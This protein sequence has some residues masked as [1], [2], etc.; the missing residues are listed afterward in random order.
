MKTISFIFLALL[1]SFVYG[2][3]NP[4]Q[5]KNKA[6]S[7][8]NEA[9]WIWHPNEA[10]VGEVVSFRKEFNMKDIPV[11]ADFTIT[12]DNSYIL[13]INGEKI[14]EDSCW[15]TLDKYDISKYLHVGKNIIS[16]DVIDEGPPGALFFVGKIKFNDGTSIK[17]FSDKNVDCLKRSDSA[18]VKA[19][20]IARLADGI[21]ACGMGG[22]PGKA[23]L[24]K[25]KKEFDNGFRN[26][27]HTQIHAKGLNIIPTPKK[28]KDL[29]KDFIIISKDKGKA[30]IVFSRNDN[31]RFLAG[32]L[33][34]ASRDATGKSMEILDAVPEGS[35]NVILIGLPQNNPFVSQ[36][37]QKRN[38]DV[39]ALP[40]D[41]YFIFPFSGGIMLTANSEQGL[42][43]AVYTFIQTWRIYGTSLIA[44]MTEIEDYPP[45]GEK[46]RGTSPRVNKAFSAFYKFN[47]IRYRIGFLFPL[48][49]SINN[50]RKFLQ[51]RGIT[52]GLSFHPG[53]LNAN[54]KEM[55]FCFSD[56]EETGRLYSRIKEAMD[57]GFKSVEIYQDDY[58]NSLLGC[59]ECE[60]KYGKGLNGLTRAQVEMMK[61][62]CKITDGKIDLAFCPRAYGGVRNPDMQAGSDKKAGDKWWQSR[63]IISESDLPNN[64]TMVTTHPKMSY[65]KELDKVYKGKP[66]FVFHNTLLPFDFRYWFEPYPPVSAEHIAYAPSWSVT[67]LGDLELWRI[68]LLCFVDALWNPGKFLPLE[69][70]FAAIYGPEN[71]E[72]LLKYSILTCGS[73]VPRGVIADCWDVPDDYPQA[74]LDTGWFGRAN[75][76]NF[77]TYKASSENIKRFQKIAEDADSAIKLIDSMKRTLPP[78]VAKKLKL[79]AERLKL[80]FEIWLEVLRFKSGEINGNVLA[81]S[82]PKARKLEKIISKMR[83]LGA[84][85]EGQ[86]GDAEFEKAI[87]KLI[88]RK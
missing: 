36:A 55:H 1:G 5:D 54:R 81:E 33:N 9:F 7:M 64:L 83:A 72:G 48:N 44:R 70:A 67:C 26:I 49:D 21:W 76:K 2:S 59:P 35:K 73:A 66:A 34:Q 58:P 80:D 69:R 38:I 56:P 68:H 20:E 50:M 27:V 84:L 74:F 30:L 15:E 16:V 88:R 11:K 29:K 40:E 41:G 60:A 18:V 25:L 19:K 22:G 62:I 71:A 14:G 13:Y 77:T 87:N 51:E 57:Y 23:G 75:K 32:L 42:I 8:L 24:E 43:Y 28:L 47:Y 52:L 53:Y 65:L 61:K 10:D 79:N 12:G 85:G 17:L 3:V 39:N 6:A 4:K 86:A 45:K 78:D 82:I 31:S 46:Y 63:K 37:C